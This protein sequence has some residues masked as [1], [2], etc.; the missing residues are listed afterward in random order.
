MFKHY[1]RPLHK[2]DAQTQE[3]QTKLKSIK[4]RNTRNHWEIVKTTMVME[5]QSQDQTAI[6]VG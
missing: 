6:H 2:K 3:I 4:R 1:T 5:D